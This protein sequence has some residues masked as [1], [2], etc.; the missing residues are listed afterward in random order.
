MQMLIDDQWVDA[1]DGGVD[2]VLDKA[3]GQALQQVPRATAAD[4]ARAVAAAQRGK[5]HM[6][7][8]PAHERCAVLMRTADAIEARIAELSTLL[9]RENGKTRREIAGELRAAVRIFRGYAEEA[10][11]LFGR[12]T[13]LDSIPGQE[14]SMAITVRQP[15]GVVAAIVP[16]NYPIELWAHKVAGALAAGNAVITKPPEQCPITLLEIAGLLRAA[17]LPPAAHQVLTGPGEVED[18]LKHLFAVLST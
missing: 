13:P 16:F 15:R 17:G 18:E 6:A 8:L 4:V 10:K 14:R 7:A 2:D 12:T 5:R 1:S 3:T 9:T 11:R